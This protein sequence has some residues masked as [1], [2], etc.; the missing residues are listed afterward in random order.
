MA[1]LSLR[2]NITRLTLTIARLW[3]I[4]SNSSRKRHTGSRTSTQVL[5]VQIWMLLVN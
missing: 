5:V 4:V 3:H 2:E 1:H